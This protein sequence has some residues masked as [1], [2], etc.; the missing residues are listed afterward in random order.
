MLSLLDKH[1]TKF[2][3]KLSE[4]DN[5][6]E[7]IKDAFN[8]L[9]DKYRFGEVR[10]RYTVQATIN[11][12]S[13]E[14]DRASVFLDRGSIDEKNVYTKEFHTGE[15]GKGVLSLVALKGARPWTDEEKSDLDVILDILFFHMG[16][17]RLMGIVKHN[18]RSA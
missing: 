16:K 13:D 11:H 12:P 6:L 9:V 14:D 5:S 10:A 17:F 8:E 4:N 3:Q 1:F 18:D 2:I 15:N 7:I